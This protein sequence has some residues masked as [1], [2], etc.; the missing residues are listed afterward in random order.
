MPTLLVTALLFARTVG[1]DFVNWDDDVNLL[2]NR[3]VL[4]FDVRG[5]FTESVIGNYNPL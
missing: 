2:E 1:F 5:I 3:S 4:Q